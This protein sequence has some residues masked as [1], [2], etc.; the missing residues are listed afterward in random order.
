MRSGSGFEF[1]MAPNKPQQQEQKR[2]NPSI[3]LYDNSEL[4]PRV[5]GPFNDGNDFT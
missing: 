4:D 1:G 5:H 2:L 3:Y